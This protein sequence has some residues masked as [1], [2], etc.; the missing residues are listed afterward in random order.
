MREVLELAAEVVPTR[1]PGG[2]LVPYIGEAVLKLREGYDLV[3]N[4]AP[5]G[6][7]VSSMGEAITPGIHAAAPGCRG[8]IQPLF[9]QQGDIDAELIQTALLKTVG[10]ER[11]YRR[12]EECTEGEGR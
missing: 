11:F 3:L 9:S 8:K 4:V 7:M 2:E 1:R 10:P 5:E 12:A 6:C